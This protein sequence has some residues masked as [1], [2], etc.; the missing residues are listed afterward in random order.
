MKTG[1]KSRCIPFGEEPV[2]DVCVCCG[3]PATSWFT[4][5]DSIDS[6][7]LNRKGAAS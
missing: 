4:G 1:I 2:S 7:I 6:E 3:K 5:A